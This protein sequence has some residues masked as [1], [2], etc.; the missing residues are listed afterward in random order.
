MNPRRLRLTS[1]SAASLCAVN[2]CTTHLNSIPQLRHRFGSLISKKNNERKQ[3]GKAR[4]IA[5]SIA[6]T[7]V[8]P[9]VTLIEPQR[10][11]NTCA[12]LYC[13]GGGIG[14]GMGGGC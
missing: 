11:H 1:Q 9:F 10:G 2:A 3:V 13:G 5:S 6:H 7:G 8:E 4:I 14:T 12:Q